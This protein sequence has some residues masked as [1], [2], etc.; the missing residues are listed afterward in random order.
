MRKF[1][2]LFTV[3][4]IVQ[5]PLLAQ[6]QPAQDT[7]KTLN[8]VVISAFEQKRDIANGTIVKLIDNSNADRYNKTSLVNS[9]NSIAGVRMEERSPGSYRINIR[10]S[11][12]RSPFGVRNVKV[13]WNDIPVTDPGGNTYINQFSVNNFASIE[14]FKGPAGSLYGAGTGGLLLMHSMGNTWKPGVQLEYVGGSYGLN[15]VL[16]TASFG[17]D[18]NRHQLTYAHNESDGYRNHSRTKK[19]NASFVSQIKLSGKEQITASVLYSSQLYETPGGLTLSEYNNNPRQ[20]R[21][22]AGGQP[23]ADQARATIY[24]K[25]FMAG[26]SHAYYF[27]PA[28]KNTTTLYG[29]FAQVQNPTFRNYERRNEPSLGGR[30]SFVYEKQLHETRIQLVGGAEV[31][32]GFFNTQVSKNKNGQP[33]TLQTNDDIYYSTYSIFAQ[34]DISFKDSWVLTAGASINKS[35]VRFT[36]LSSYPT[37]QQSRSYKSEL[38]PRLAL[39]KKLGSRVALFGS[40]SKGF[41]PP[42]VAELLPSTGVISTFLEAEEGVNYEAGGRVTLLNGRLRL[43]AT[44]FYFKLNNALVTR[45][46]SSNA[47]YYV[48]AGNTKQQGLEFSADYT[49][50]FSNRFISYIVI[51]PSYTV[52]DFTYGSFIK[53]NTNYAGKYL[54]SVPKHIFSVLADIQ[55]AMGLYLNTSYYTASRI[56]LDDANTAATGAYH[57]LAGR[58]GF[59]MPVKKLTLNLYVGADNLL[60]ENYSLGNDINAAGGRYYNAA[61]AR[62]YYAGLALQWVKKG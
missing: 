23:S 22:A 47:D 2:R 20:A 15:N 13:Y 30:T 24:Q 42:S 21:P 43:E 7:V 44:G 45:K 34:A 61:P 57:L 11:S 37:N 52:N 12:L 18:E 56:Y 19:D 10:G 62:N 27:T 17:K 32:Q 16:T 60:N 28:F 14:I 9:F 49:R 1:I 31:Q 53:G 46:D 54:P 55:T 33:D 4:L 58:V 40:V 50:L 41:S 29:M 36:R 35:T 39:L 5:Q 59:K 48:N 38:S 51:R 6:D 3:F 25:N 26:I 8:E